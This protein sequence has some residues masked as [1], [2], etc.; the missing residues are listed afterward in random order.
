VSTLTE[1]LRGVLGVTTPR[2]AQGLAPDPA[3]PPASAP[4][5]PTPGGSPALRPSDAVAETLGGTW[6]EEAGH[7]YLVVDR[8][9][10]AGHRHGRLTVADAMPGPDGLWPR[11]D[12]LLSP[13]RQPC[14]GPREASPFRAEH[15]EAGHLLFVDLETTGLAG[16]AGSYAFLVGCAWFETGRLRV[17][18]FFLSSF[19]AEAA[20]LTG[21]ARLAGRASGVVTYN[22]KS[23]DLPLLETRYV[24]NRLTLP[25]L[26]LPHVDLL[27]PARRLWKE[28]E[29]DAMARPG[30]SSC[31]L[32]SLERT[33]CGFER[34]G[35]VPGFEIPGRYFGYVREGDARPLEAVLE[36]NRLD[37]VS[38]ALLTG[39]VA[40][41]LEGG[42]DTA[43]TAREALGLGRLLER[44]GRLA[45]A[46][47]AFDR[48]ARLTGPADV[49]AEALQA[50]AHLHRRARQFGDAAGVWVRLLALE[51]CPAALA[52][53]ASEALAIHHEHRQR[54]VSTARR[55]ALLSLDGEARTARQ[56]GLRR[57]LSRL[58]RKLGGPAADGSDLFSG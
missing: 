10:P 52:R 15:G 53:E 29:A 43:S 55:Y 48:A 44:G 38:L 27:H 6:H 35:D 19:G 47:E 2:P 37:L 13:G 40:Q 41:K 23:F 3:P 49:R 8:S 22:G 54:D 11:L 25:L 58:D 20:L 45:E 18:Q 4:V 36:H 56:A 17:R 16:G 46:G 31:K 1:R 30:A 9:F 7:R 21:V 32:T 50:R 34:E 12:L 14:T 5:P 42:G 33:Q 24:L 51:G 57:R 26:E 39:L 28:P